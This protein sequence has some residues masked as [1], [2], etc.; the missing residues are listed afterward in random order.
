M[1][2]KVTQGHLIYHC[3]L[4]DCSNN[5]SIS[6]RLRDITTREVHV[7]VCDLEKSLRCGKTVEI[8]SHVRFPIHVKI[9]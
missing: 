9:S 1:T 5:A 3:L 7:T 6:H 4:L 8:T 2:L